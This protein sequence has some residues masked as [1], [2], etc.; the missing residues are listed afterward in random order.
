MSRGRFYLR[1]ES[2]EWDFIRSLEAPLPFDAAVVSD[3]YLP[4]YPEGHPRHG[5]DRDRLIQALD[6]QGA[7]WSVDPDT[8]RLEQAKS[9]QRQGAR[10]ASRPL[11]RAVALPLTAERLASDDN[12]DALAEAAAV[13][14][15]RSPAFAAPYLEVDGVD[16]MR[17]DVNLMLL[18]R[19]RELAGDRALVAYLQVLAG[20]L[21]DGAAVG[22]ARGLA[23]N[24]AEV[25]FIRVRRFEAQ[26][27]TESEVVAY[28]DVVEAGQRAG[29]RMVADSVG[30]LG[31]VL[32]A[33]GADGFASNAR[34]FRKVPDD[35]HPSG[36]GGGAGELVWEIPGGG[37]ATV[38]ARPSITC[39]VPECLAPAAEGDN[40]AVR[41]HNLHEFQRAARQA[42]A[43][44]LG[45]AARLAHDSSPVVRGWARALQLLERRAA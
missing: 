4:D 16:D 26:H 6:A 24:G 23:E 5:E 31:P 45:Y 21:L 29:A 8:A 12:V 39:A 43:E 13:H 44:G 34:C 35:L 10:A 30:R 1:A 27:A 18:Q 28:A 17:F 40:S 22:V 15:L 36:G 11:A 2:D 41:I 32:V 14:Q 9:A 20:R 33:T 19:S 7:R 42:G 25:I 37:F 3:R 38:G